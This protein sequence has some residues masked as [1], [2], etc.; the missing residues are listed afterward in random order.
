MA[1]K[2]E[3]RPLLRN[4]TISF[5]FHMYYIVLI[6]ALI[7]CHAEAILGFTEKEGSQ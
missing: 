3:P 5:I 7:K 6:I 4:L 2:W 1:Q